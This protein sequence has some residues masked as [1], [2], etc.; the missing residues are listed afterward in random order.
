[1][2]QRV[3][4]SFP[5]DY[6]HTASIFK[7][8]LIC[9]F[10][11]TVI[12]LQVSRLYF[13][14]A[15]GMRNSLWRKDATCCSWL[16]VPQPLRVWGWFHRFFSLN[17]GSFKGKVALCNTG[18]MVLYFMRPHKDVHIIFTSSDIM[19][20]G[21]QRLIWSKIFLSSCHKSWFPAAQVKAS[22]M[23]CMNTSPVITAEAS[24]WTRNLSGL[25]NS[26]LW[27]TTDKRVERFHERRTHFLYPLLCSTGLHLASMV[28]KWLDSRLMASLILGRKVALTENFWN[29]TTSR[30]R[31]CF[32]DLIS[33]SSTSKKKCLSF[34]F[35][36]CPTSL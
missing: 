12:C 35:S 21:Y 26:R 33:P 23:P 25:W 1:M 13:P 20:Y 31:R 22:S 24:T 14:D 4:Q 32:W 9:F 2:W 30:F 10:F 11:W 15:R 6:R 28:E 36:H 7:E 34:L 19:A 17:D 16:S 27:S 29:P 5:L 18:M 8:P 3:Q